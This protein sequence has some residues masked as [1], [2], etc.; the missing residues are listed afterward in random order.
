MPH[1]HAKRFFPPEWYPQDAVML[2][3]PQKGMDWSYIFDEVEACF[4][5]I[6][7]EVLK[8]ERLLVVCNE[9]TEALRQLKNEE[10]H[11]YPLILIENVELNDTWARDIAPLSL[12]IDERP[13]LI[14]MAFN[15]W[16]NK[17]EAD[18]DNNL[19][20]HLFNNTYVFHKDVAYLSGLDFVCEGGSLETDGAGVLL[21]TDSVILES[22]RNPTLSRDSILD[23]LKRTFGAE[24]VVSL[25]CKPL[26]GDDTDGHADTLFRFCREDT[27]CYVGVPTDKEDR[28]Y[29]QLKEMEKEI[30]SLSNAKGEPYKAH[31][32][33]YLGSIQDPET[34]E[35]LP[36]TY[37]NFLILNGAVLLPI[38][39]APEDELAVEAL[40]DLFPERE[41]VP[42]NCFP[43]VR[44]HGSLHCLTMQFPKGFISK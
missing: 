1:Y 40:K 21:T 26:Q 9:A 23:I 6:A 13:V 22:H 33:P 16:G 41:I 29:Q 3:W 31:A 4:L 25:S 20:R 44:Q 36:A 8:R 10:Q 24:K 43:I 17:F 7:R 34:G 35:P 11:P 2:C 27:L 37:A 5:S 28:H 38:Y 30:L 15:G 42:I 19:T 14:D 32:L 18:K 39:G 12:F